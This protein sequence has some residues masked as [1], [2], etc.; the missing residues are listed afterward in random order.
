M[1]ATTVEPSTSK[2]F[3]GQPSGLATLI[4]VGLWERFSFYGMQVVLLY[5]LYF[6][7]SQ[8]GLGLSMATAT[9]VVGAYGGLV[10][11]STIL[12]GWVADRLLGS[13]RT[14]LYS[15]VVILLGHVC[16][17]VIPGLTGVWVGL[18]L[19]VIGS[20][21]QVG[22]VTSLAGALYDTHDRRRDRGFMLFYMGL[23]AGALAG[24]IVTG[25][26]RTSM[27][28]HY[29]FGLAA[30]GMA[31]ALS[32]YVRGRGKLHERGRH[33]PDPL[34]RSGAMRAL[35]LAAGIVICCVVGAVTG[36]L[37]ARHLATVV[38]VVLCVLI[39]S[40][41][42]TMLRSNKVTAMERRRV[43]ALIPMFVVNTAFWALYQQQFTVVQIYA[44]T[45]VDLRVFGLAMPPEF[46]NSAV[47]V[48][49]ILCTPLLV[50]LWTRLGTREPGTPV[51]FLIGIL[52]IGIS[53]LLFL[54]MAGST[55]AVN[56]PLALAGILLVFTLAELF[57]SPVQL[58]LSTK[59]APNAFRTQMVAL[60]FLSTAAGS[61]A[62]GALAGFYT[63]ASEP[64]YFSLS[65]IAAI[66]VG[67]LFALTIPWTK[68]MMTGV[69]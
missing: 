29:G 54:P 3:L 69:R 24:P 2:E 4:G 68:K 49:V 25:L 44:A 20:G 33:V 53:Y 5:Y 61:A 10:Y 67:G 27:G 11:L 22:N 23:N 59:L 45:R 41:F 21:G 63:P 57:V 46:F 51:K 9:S 60:W 35:A 50:W 18:G 16:L 62:A 12:G 26:T 38:V 42:T 65:G 47:P 37:S 19:L 56:P 15:A 39:V 48:F 43:Y 13:E 32:I 36:V 6:S 58:S 31:I 40:Y 8:G 17:A 7:V 14:L 64:R 52:G 66:I 1:T 28:F 30:I 34:S 55:G